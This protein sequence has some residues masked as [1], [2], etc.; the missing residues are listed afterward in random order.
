[1]PKITFKLPD[2]YQL[3]DGVRE[4]GDQFDAVVKLELGDEGKVTLVSLDRTPMAPGSEDSDE[5]GFRESVM[6]SYSE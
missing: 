6:Q 3:P 2:G 5:A 4:K 1:M